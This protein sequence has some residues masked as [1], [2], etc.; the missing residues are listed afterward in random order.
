MLLL[1]LGGGEGVRKTTISPSEIL[2][3]PPQF[4]MKSDTQKRF[5]RSHPKLVLPLREA[6]K[7]VNVGC[8]TVSASK[9]QCLDEKDTKWREEGAKTMESP[10]ANFLVG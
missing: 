4:D 5:H 1:F 10:S 6:L 7:S 2:Q 3:N 9:D 8:K